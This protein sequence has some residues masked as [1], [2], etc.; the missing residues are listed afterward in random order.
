MPKNPPIESTHIAVKPVVKEAV[1]DIR[2]I[3]KGLQM[4]KNAA[5]EKEEKAKKEQKQKELLAQ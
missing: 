3:M 1:T 2:I 4:E 5:R